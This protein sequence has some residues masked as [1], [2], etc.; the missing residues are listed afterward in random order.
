MTEYLS[1]GNV[2]TFTSTK[3]S[4]IV[5]ASR[6]SPSWHPRRFSTCSRRDHPV[7]T[8]E[9]LTANTEWNAKDIIISQD[10]WIG[11][12]INLPLEFF[13]RVVGSLGMKEKY[14]T[15]IVLL[16]ADEWVL[17]SHHHHEVNV[18][19][20]LLQV[21]L[22]LLPKATTAANKVVLPLGF[23]FSLLSKCIQLGLIYYQGAGKLQKQIV[24]S[25]HLARV[26]DFLD[27]TNLSVMETLFSTYYYY[28]YSAA[29]SSDSPH[30]KHDD[31]IVAQLWDLYLNQVAAHNSELGHERFVNLIEIVPISS[32]QTHDYLYTAISTYFQLHQ[33]LSQQVKGLICRYLNCQKLSQEA[34][35]QAVQNEMMPLRLIVRAL[36]L[37]QL[38]TQQAFK[39]CSNSFRYTHDH[40]N[41]YVDA[42]DQG[43]EKDISENSN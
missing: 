13:K 14:V 37:Q 11:N 38:N 16:Y 24:S 17:S 12:L 18:G 41:P 26:Q 35:I 40:E 31:F 19:V 3:W 1:P 39:E 28:Y 29:S 42:S 6:P 15:P 20:L 8:V 22:D 4:S 27:S 43:V 34:C 32:R 5:A 25:L 7:V 23:Y 30:M 10:P 9:A 2:S 33:D 36:F 21:V